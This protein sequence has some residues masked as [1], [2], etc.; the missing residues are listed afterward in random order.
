[1][2]VSFR[3]KGSVNEKLRIFRVRNTCFLRFLRF[4]VFLNKMAK[5][6]LI[7][8]KLREN[9]GEIR[10]NRKSNEVRKFSPRDEL[11]IYAFFF[12]NK[13]YLSGIKIIAMP[14]ITRISE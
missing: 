14:K 3:P 10:Y 4:C 12:L 9:V 13:F 1:M 7:N 2:V 5:Y 8:T 11:I 6:G